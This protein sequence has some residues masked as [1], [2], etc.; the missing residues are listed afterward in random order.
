MANNDMKVTVSTEDIVSD[1]LI[2]IAN[3]VSKLH[4]LRV[5]SVHF[6]W[7]MPIGMP[8]KVVGIEMTTSK[9]AE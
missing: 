8:C 4:G 5:K 9:G 3:E 7:I 2:K 6:K 1:A